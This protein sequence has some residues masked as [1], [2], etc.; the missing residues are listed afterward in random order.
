VIVHDGIWSPAR[1]D[2]AYDEWLRGRDASGRG[3][4]P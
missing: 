2:A 1:V 3:V 4:E